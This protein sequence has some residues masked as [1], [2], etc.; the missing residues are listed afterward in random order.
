MPLGTLTVLFFIHA[1]LGHLVS[2]WLEA[3]DEIAG[4][5][6]TKPTGRHARRNLQQIR[7]NTLVEALD[8]FLG[9]NHSHCVSERFVPVAHSG[10]SIDLESPT[11][12]VADGRR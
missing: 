8:P 4:D 3:C 6:E 9:H 7:H 11:Q 12:N 5:F 10:H 1:L 2:F